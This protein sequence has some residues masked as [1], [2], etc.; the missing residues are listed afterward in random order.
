MKKRT[1]IIALAGVALIV[2][3]ISWKVATGTS[4]T[5]DQPI[6]AVPA[7]STPPPRIEISEPEEIATIQP[8]PPTLAAETKELPPEPTLSEEEKQRIATELYYDRLELR[9]YQQLEQLES[10]SD[11][12]RRLSSIRSMSRYVRVDT[13]AAIEWAASLIDPDEQRR[14][15][16]LINKNAVT[17]IGARIEMNDEGLP[18][19]RNTTI[20]SAAESTG[21]IEPG[22]SISGMVQA[23]GTTVSFEGMNIRE[24]VSY[25]RGVPGSEIELQMQRTMPNGE[26]YSFEVPT[27][28]SLIVMQR[29]SEY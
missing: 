2:G 5:P 21:L 26:A 25:L 18:T 9:F 27:Q 14:A 3:A 13:L 1:C 7:R 24:V 8:A 22:D 23:D 20:L 12:A 19:I 4:E 28:R 16:E 29:P 17:G 15:Q 11:P 6:V 10:T